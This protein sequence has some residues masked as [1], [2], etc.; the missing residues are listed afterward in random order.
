MILTFSQLGNC[1]RLGNQ[2]F[3]YATLRS[4]GI[5]LN[6]QTKI[7]NGNYSLLNFNI[8]KNFLNKNNNKKLNIYN[9]KH[10]HYCDDVFNIKEN[11]DIVGYFQSYKYFDSIKNILIKEFNNDDINNTCNEIIENI[12]KKYDNKQIT[13]LHLRRGDY[14]NYPNVHPICS[15]NY[16]E[17]CIEHFTDNIF[18]IFSD[19]ITWCQNNLKFENKNIGYININEIADLI[20]MSKC[21]NNIISNSSYSWWAAYLNRNE[22]KRIFYPNIWFGKDGPQDIFDLIPQSWNMEYV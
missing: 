11:T 20:L 19:D 14:I 22:N 21:D 15:Y 12:K 2:M 17:K 7:P 18:L 13:S 9:E 8:N 16:F 5:S 6:M 1:G 10:F 3:Q 4:V